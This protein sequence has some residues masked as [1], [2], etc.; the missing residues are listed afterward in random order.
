[1]K[2]SVGGVGK[3]ARSTHNWDTLPH[4]AWTGAR[5][6]NGGEFEVNVVGYDEVESAV[7]IVVEEGAPGTPFFSSPGDSGLFGYV[8][9]S[10]IPLIVE[11]MIFTVAGDIEVVVAIIVIVPD[12]CALAPAGESDCGAS[13]DIGKSSVVVVMEEVT[14]GIAFRCGGVERGA[15]NE[16]D[17]LPAVA[18][19][20]EDGNAGAG[21]LEDVALGFGASV[22]VMNEDAGLAG[23][24]DEPC[25]GGMIRVGW[26]EL[27]LSVGDEGRRKKE[28]DCGQQAAEEA[29][30]SM[31]PPYVPRLGEEIPDLFQ[32]KEHQDFGSVV[33]DSIRPIG[34]LLR[35]LPPSSM[36]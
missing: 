4:A 6:R 17:V 12:T 23:Y 2:E 14:C 34:T 25:R 22:D 3:S 1:M 11:E 29:D 26:I 15:I 21:G 24:V 7:T 28:G 5:L 32:N 13:S 31:A 16:E 18:V 9:E 35:S 33:F 19:V 36:T 8:F 20:V 27:R 30:L 10:P